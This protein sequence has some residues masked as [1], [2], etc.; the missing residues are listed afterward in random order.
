LEVVQN[1]LSSKSGA[2]IT[3]T[4]KEGK[5]ALLMAAGVKCYP[6]I[7]QWLL[8][9]GVAQTTDTDNEGDSVWTV[10]SGE[11]LSGMLKGA[12]TKSKDREYVSVDGK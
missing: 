12:H 1:L 9:Y 6:T 8:E 2:S 11:G 7:I 10:D 5:T 3:E 4:D